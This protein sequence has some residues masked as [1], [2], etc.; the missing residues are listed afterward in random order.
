MK[1]TFKVNLNGLNGAIFSSKDGIHTGEFTVI[2]NEVTINWSGKPED[3]SDDNF[4][5]FCE[6]VFAL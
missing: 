5:D 3:Y 6:F 1:K 4:Q 2:G